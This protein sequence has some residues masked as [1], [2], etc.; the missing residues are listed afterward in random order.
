MNTI[1]KISVSQLKNIGLEM[2]V[3]DDD[4]ILSNN[5]EIKN[6]IFDTPCRN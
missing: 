5:I 3:L 2:S 1:E 6:K 4:I